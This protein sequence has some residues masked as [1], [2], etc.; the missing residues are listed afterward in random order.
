MTEKATLDFVTKKPYSVDDVCEYSAIV[1]TP[2]YIVYY[3][4][5]KEQ[6]IEDAKDNM[7][8]LMDYYDI[9]FDV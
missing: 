8:R 5:W 7:L 6:G 4:Y 9:E 3:Y 1:G 2:L